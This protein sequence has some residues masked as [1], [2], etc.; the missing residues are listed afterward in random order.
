MIVAPFVALLYDV[1]AGLVVLV[2]T[3][4]ATTYLAIDLR[5]TAPLEILP[6]L[7]ILIRINLALLGI[8]AMVLVGRLVT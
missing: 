5:R 6:R 8:C 3:L 4:A 1:T 2:F 7:N